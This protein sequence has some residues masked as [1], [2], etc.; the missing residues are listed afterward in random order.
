MIEKHEIH[1]NIFKK[2]INHSYR[3]IS[4]S[5][6]FKT[7]NFKKHINKVIQS[8]SYNLKF[9]KS[10][11]P[12]KQPVCKY[13]NSCLQFPKKSNKA[14]IDNMHQISPLLRWQVNKNYKN[15]Y[16]DLF[17]DNESFVEIIGPSGLLIQ[18]NIR[19]GFLLLGEDILYPSHYHE[20]IEL[21]HIISGVSMWQMHKDKFLKKEP[22][23][24]VFHDECVPHS[25]KTIGKPVLAL[26]SWTGVIGSEAIPIKD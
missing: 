21:Y 2:I 20:A 10:Y 22:G 23:D 7:P 16:S 15:V 13:L 6:Y 5:N 24:Y 1:L 26:F 12:N 18:D 19:V 4:E 11:F 9:N 8:T 3:S 25:M 17:F 14:L